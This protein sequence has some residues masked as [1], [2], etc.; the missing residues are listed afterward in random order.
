MVVPACFYI[1]ILLFWV[2][3][4]FFFFS[5]TLFIFVVAPRC[6]MLYMHA[7]SYRRLMLV[8]QLRCL[9]RNASFQCGG[10]IVDESSKIELFFFLQKSNVSR[11][12]PFVRLHRCMTIAHT[13]VIASLIPT[14]L[15]FFFFFLFLTKLISFASPRG[16]SAY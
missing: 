9:T 13:R 15:F 5:C 16:I 7:N 14:N 1:Y 10:S 3:K 12:R 11:N 8:L 2:Y 4:V 6:L